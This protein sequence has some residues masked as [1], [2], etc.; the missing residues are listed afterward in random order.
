MY[1]ALIF[2]LDNTIL[3][4]SLSEFDSMK[5]TVRDHN[6]F[7]EEEEAKWESFWPSYLDHNLKHWMDFVH[8]RGPHENIHDVLRSSFRDTLNLSPALHHAL[9][10]TYWHYFCH[11]CHFE[12]GAE[13]VL[14]SLGARYSFGIISNGISE[15]QR[16]RLVAGNILDQ[17]QSIIV[18]DEVGIRKPRK[19]IFDL[20]LRELGLDRRE[21][22]FIGD[23]LTDDYQG[24][25]NAGIDF[26]YY[27][28]SKAPVPEEI[29]PAYAIRELRELLD[30]I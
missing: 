20:S 29:K 18:S 15:A 21:V 27:N 4:Y 16:K 9:S 1:K 8:Q 17:F 14:G 28:R 30:V 25:V 10:D 19:E 7:A 2:D 12:D 5:R 26:C 6:L 23:S 22:L 24:A 13:E 3:N 11:T